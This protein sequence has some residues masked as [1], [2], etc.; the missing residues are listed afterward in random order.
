M[1]KNLLQD[2]L[3]ETVEERPDLALPLTLK[4]FFPVLPNQVDLKIPEGYAFSR[5][6][7]ITATTSQ[8]TVESVYGSVIVPTA[9]IKTDEDY[10]E[11]VLRLYFWNN[12]KQTWIK[13]HLLVDYQMLTTTKDISKL[14]KAMQIVLKEQQKP[15]LT[16]YFVMLWEANERFES[17]PTIIQ[18]QRCGWDGPNNFY[19]FIITN[20]ETFVKT[21]IKT[22]MNAIIRT[23]IDLPKGNKDEALEIIAELQDNPVFAVCLAGCLASPIVPLVAGKLDENIGID[24]Y[25]KT[26]AGKAAIQKLA[27][28]LVYGM[29]NLFRLSWANFKSAGMWNMARVANN[30]VFICNI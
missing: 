24:I 9:I 2:T 19:P 21:K 20:E 15:A 13:H 7:G 23:A 30:L 1:D 22:L 5:E 26:T 28:D 3:N 8:T 27:I 10:H 18:T 4:S 14:N 12:N 6:H 29:G 16:N 17:L 25:G 11:P